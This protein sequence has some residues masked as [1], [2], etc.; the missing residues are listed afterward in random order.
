MGWKIHFSKQLWAYTYFKR[1]DPRKINMNYAPEDVTEFLKESNLIEDV[2]DEYSLLCATSAWEELTKYKTSITSKKILKVHR[3][4]LQHVR[5]DIAGRFRHCPVYIGGIKKEFTSVNDI[6]NQVKEW[7]RKCDTWKN[8]KKS[9]EKKEAIA[10]EWHI[11]FENI[12]PF[13]DGNGRIGRM[14][15]NLHRNRLGLPIDIIRYNERSAY[16]KWFKQ[17]PDYQDYLEFIAHRMTN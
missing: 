3:L 8:S 1:I 17:Y 5:K 14:L 13:E 16:Y 9:K 6:K 7:I 12:H 10:I 11:A 2:T 4:L 15:Y